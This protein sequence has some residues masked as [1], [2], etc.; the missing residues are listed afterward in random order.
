MFSHKKLHF[1]KSVKQNKNFCKVFKNFILILY[2]SVVNVSFRANMFGKQ[3][4]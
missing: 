1:K 2:L 3:K 4:I